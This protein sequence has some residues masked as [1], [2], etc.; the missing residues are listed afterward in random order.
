MTKK[1]LLGFAALLLA[2]ANQAP[3]TVE[4]RL[5]QDIAV[6][7]GDDLAGR[8]P[9]TPGGDQAI[10]YIVRR[11][12]DIGLA[13]GLAGGKWAQ[14]VDVEGKESANLIGRIAGSD[15]AGGAVVMTAH[16]DHLGLCQPAGVA[17]RICNGA[18]DNASGVALMIEV[19]RLLAAGPKPHRTIFFVATTGEEEGLIG[20]RAFITAPP[21]P[22][23][24]IVAAINL[25]CPATA[26][27]GASVGIVGRGMTRLDPIVDAE[28]RRLGRRI[29]ASGWANQFVKRQDGWA[30]LN[31]G[32]PAV[33]IGGNVGDHASLQAFLDGTYHRPNDDLAHLPP[34]AGAAEDSL[35]LAA[36]IRAFADPARLPATVKVTHR[37]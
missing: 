32:V 14:R 35:L 37:S 2:T 25:D 11:F 23:D 12:H 17:D 18:V 1:I 20:A 31:A 10:A 6:L 24:D 21:V 28:A 9:G 15:R 36:T 34:L 8:A 3:Q 4:A 27:A 26:P 30:F 29:D 5:H 22:R 19:A 7:A 16:W 33:M 13:P